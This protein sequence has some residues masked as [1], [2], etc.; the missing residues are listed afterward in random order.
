MGM[1]EIHTD[2][3]ATP[4]QMSQ[5][6]RYLN[7]ALRKNITSIFLAATK[8]IYIAQKTHSS[9]LRVFSFLETSV[10]TLGG[11]PQGELRV[12][13]QIAGFSKPAHLPGC[14]VSN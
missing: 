5:E 2:L 8:Q 6:L 3:N 1:S 10:A 14:S 9:N 12:R 11:T 7:C 13:K 4:K